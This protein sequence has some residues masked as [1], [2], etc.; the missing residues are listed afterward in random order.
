MCPLIR[1]DRLASG[2]V[3]VRGLSTVSYQ[4]TVKRVIAFN[5]QQSKM[6]VSSLQRERI[7]P[8]LWFVIMVVIFVVGGGIK[9]TFGNINI[10]NRNKDD[11]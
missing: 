2:F 6:N 7:M 10:N 5:F 11:D 9:V 1:V 8:D 3:Q 4:D